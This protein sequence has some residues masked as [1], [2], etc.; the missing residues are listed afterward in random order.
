LKF[1]F[2]ITSTFSSKSDYNV[3]Y[4]MKD[5]F[6]TTQLQQYYLLQSFHHSTVSMLL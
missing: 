1:F 5:P 6:P 3:G 2:E 4:H